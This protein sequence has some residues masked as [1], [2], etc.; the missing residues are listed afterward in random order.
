MLTVT[1]FGGSG[2]IGRA[3]VQKFAERGDRIR[4]AVRNPLSAQFLKPLGEI[5]QIIPIQASVT[6]IADIQHAIEGSDIVI[7]L[8]GLLYESGSQTFEAIH[9]EGAKSI[10]KVASKLGIPTLLH[11]SALG[12]TK[13]SKSRYA[14]TKA[15]GE[16]AVLKHFPRAIVFRPSIVFGPQDAF[17]N[18]FASMAR[19][20]PALPL[21][22]GGHTK[23]QPIYVEDVADCFMNSIHF[24]QFGGKIFELGGPTVYSFKYLMEYLLEVI[25]RRRL[26]IPVPFMMAKGM[27]SIA[28]FFP[29]VPL[30][31]DQVELLK[32]DN[33]LTTQSLK[34]EDLHVRPKAMETIVPL[35]LERYGRK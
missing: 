11:M 4:V 25:H 22:G 14:S 21:I 8:V 30:T 24:E 17:F 28:Q 9:V 35:Y 1:L 2:F 7:N 27:A 34:A 29:G 13:G 20:S 15:R 5:G 31:P 10:A 26:L 6:S 12:V 19:Y 18:R 3:L 33:I 23:M 32:T 16:E